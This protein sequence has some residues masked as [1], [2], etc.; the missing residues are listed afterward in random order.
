[1]SKRKALPG[2]FLD[3]AGL[4]RQHVFDLD[5]LPAEVLATL[6]VQAGETQLILIGHAGRR[7]WEC[8]QAS[9]ITG[10]D[11]IDD[12]SMQTVSRWFA[13]ELPDRRFRILFPGERVI[14]LQT[15]GKLAGWHQ[16][17]PI[18]VGV[19]VEW[20]SWYAY[21]AV[22]VA[23]TDF[24]P[25][26]VLEGRSPC[27]TC[28][29]PCITAC[30]ANA[31]DQGRFDLDACSHYRLRPDSP[32]AH[33]CLARQACPAGS[34]HRYDEAQIRHSYSRS[35]AVIREYY[36]PASDQPERP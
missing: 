24:A 8:V 10:S 15:L 21:R 28:A 23:D 22:V 35:L 17:S 34:A 25:S 12:Y 1:M 4:N 33:G 20:G 29:A 32:C 16:P 9:G 31:L 13:Q 14:G 26:S 19:D 2:S 18:M 11:P 3:D 7:L 5:S 36:P 27:P 6:G 30:P